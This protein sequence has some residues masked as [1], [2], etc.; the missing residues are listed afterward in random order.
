MAT[1]DVQIYHVALPRTY[2]YVRI[3]RLPAGYKPS[4]VI[5]VNANV[6]YGKTV[7]ACVA[8]DGN[9]YISSRPDN[10]NNDVSAVAHIT[11]NN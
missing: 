8:T 10:T 6:D 4:T 3:G 5:D 7:L 2:A 9:I 11:W 1:L